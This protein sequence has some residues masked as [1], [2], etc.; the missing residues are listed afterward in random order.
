[1]TTTS[2]A[3]IETALDELRQGRMIIV[4]DDENRENEGD[5]LMPAETVTPEAVNF[6]IRHGR[7]LVCAPLTA[8]RAR[9]LDLDLQVARNTESMRTAFTVSVDA[10]E[11]ASTGI[12]ASD[13]ALC[14][15][16]LANPAVG[17]GA[18][19]RPGHIF[20]L[21]AENGGVFKRQGHTEAAID[22]ATLAG[23]QPVGVICEII[24][25]D[26]EMARLP[27]LELF[28]AEHHLKIISIADLLAYRKRTENLIS[29]V[30]SAPMPTD[31]GDFSFYVFRSELLGEEHMAMVKGPLAQLKQPGTLVRIHSECFTGDVLGSRR[32][33]CGSQLQEAIERIEQAGSG[34]VIYLRQEGRGIGL[35]NKIKAYQWQDQGL[36]TVEANLR[37]GLKADSRDYTMANQILTHFGIDDLRLMTN[38]P[39][40]FD[41]LQNSGVRRIERLSLSIPAN[42]DNHHYLLT[43]TRKFGHH[44]ELNPDIESIS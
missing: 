2:L 5:L 33:D 40:K 16:L 41:A 22:L 32:C 31:S 13:R 11:N 39:N 34:V 14:L 28:A 43:K 26:G 44:I 4:V 15:Q 27:D 3:S 35:F 6:M 29:E 20:P 38:N 24:K 8:E 37:L 12:S 23:F 17:A 42:A 1:M 25:D 21:I 19:N 9:V 10:R 36:D 7:G 18:F 30:E